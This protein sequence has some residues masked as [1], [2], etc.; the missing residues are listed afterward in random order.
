MYSLIWPLLQYL[1]LQIW[2]LKLSYKVNDLTKDFENY[3]WV[4]ISNSCQEKKYWKHNY[5][6]NIIHL[7]T[8]DLPYA[9]LCAGDG[10][11]S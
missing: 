5:V 10:M 6:R 3:D 4:V 2:K 9:V 8:I 11:L 1:I 7:V